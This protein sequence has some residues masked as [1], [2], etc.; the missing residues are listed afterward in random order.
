MAAK[1]TSETYARTGGDF[2]VVYLN[3]SVNRSFSRPSEY[4]PAA[5]TISKVDPDIAYN[6]TRPRGL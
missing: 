4:I 2:L 5:C 3:I 6:W 1:V